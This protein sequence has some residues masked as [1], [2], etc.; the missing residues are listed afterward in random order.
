MAQPAYCG[1]CPGRFLD[2]TGKRS[3]DKCN[4]KIVTLIIRCQLTK[5]I[6]Q[7]IIFLFH[8]DKIAQKSKRQ[9]LL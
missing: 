4:E 5:K 6:K 8:Y 9:H 3:D 2:S 1:E 7:C